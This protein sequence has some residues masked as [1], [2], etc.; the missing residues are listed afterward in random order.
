[1]EMEIN[2]I[3]NKIFRNLYLKIRVIGKF[4]IC[5]LFLSNFFMTP[6]FVQIWKTRNPPLI[7]E[8]GGEKT[9][10]TP[11]ITAIE[12]DIFRS[13]ITFWVVLPLHR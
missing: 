9:M 4:L 8:G 10:E 5:P 3:N 1:M 13:N 7:I 12:S 6:F 11:E 2:G